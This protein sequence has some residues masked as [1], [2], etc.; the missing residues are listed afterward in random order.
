MPFLIW[1]NHGVRITLLPV[2]VAFVLSLWAYRRIAPSAH[3]GHYHPWNV[4]IFWIAIILAVAGTA[5][6]IKR[7]A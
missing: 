6:A 1:I 2:V 7:L 4:V 5:L 3:D